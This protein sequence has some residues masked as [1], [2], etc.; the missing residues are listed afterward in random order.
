MTKLYTFDDCSQLEIDEVHDLYRK[1]VNSS[2]VDLLSSFDFGRELI[3]EAQG[4]W[5]T[6]KAR[7]RIMDFTGGIGVLSHGHNHPRILE[8]RRRFQEQKRMEVH[9]NYFSPYV[10]ALGHNLASILPGDLDYSFF[11]N[12][13]SEAVD[14]ALKT[15]IKYHGGKRNKILYS[16]I[17]FHGKLFG[18]ASVTCSPEN[19]FSY[20]RLPGCEQFVY[21]DIESVKKKIDE[22]RDERGQSSYAGLILEPMNVSNMRQCSP[23]FLRELRE[24]CTKEDIVLIFDE[25][26]SGWCK[27]GTLFYFMRIEGLVPD[28][29][30][31]AKSFGG[32]K[33][34]ISGIV[35][36]KP[37]FEQAFDNP[38]SANLQTSTFYAFGEETVTALEAVNIIVEDNYVGRS[39]HIE[40]RIREHFAR[41]REK[42]PKFV[43][44]ARGSGAIHGVFLNAGPEILNKMIGLLPG[45][46]FDDANFMKK[47]VTAAVVSDLYTEH[48]ILT[49]ISLGVD[50]HLIVAPSLIVE[51]DELDHF[52]ECLDKTLSKGLMRLVTTFAK[53]KFLKK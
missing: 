19:N 3:S 25:V 33:A 24:I 29:L 40:T 36:R 48:D 13:G 26:Y 14:G 11:P 5:L 32:G 45:E 9:K 38:S 27:A 51:D 2:R 37:I 41:L 6:T 4:I 16:D 8:V 49:F 53:K 18:P 50:I 23:E 22:S 10:A 20:P 46:L 47:L 31:M 21:D 52:F 39:Q 1:H 15:A 42:H 12:S 35:T 17:A 30:C 34:S 7:R 28:V 44:D 43:R